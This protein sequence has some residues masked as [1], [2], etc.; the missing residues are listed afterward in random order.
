MMFNPNFP[1][2][3]YLP[4]QEVKQTIFKIRVEDIKMKIK[5]F[6]FHERLYEWIASVSAAI[7]HD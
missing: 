1:L 6:G 3:G 7:S 4:F 2:Q 5:V